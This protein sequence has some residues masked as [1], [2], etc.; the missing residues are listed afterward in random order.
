MGDALNALFDGCERV[1]VFDASGL[2]PSP[3]RRVFPARIIFRAGRS[4][5]GVREIDIVVPGADGL[6]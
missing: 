3:S 2:A 6:G 4:R 5:L 1:I